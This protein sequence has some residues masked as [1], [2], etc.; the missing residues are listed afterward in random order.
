MCSEAETESSGG[1]N[2][3]FSPVSSVL[4]NY[5]EMENFLSKA[6]LGILHHG[7]G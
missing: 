2:G 5:G 7:P 6:C 3:T 1:Q 4:G